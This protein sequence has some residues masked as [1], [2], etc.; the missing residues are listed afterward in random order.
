MVLCV[1]IQDSYISLTQDEFENLDHIPG[2]DTDFLTPY[3]F[4]KSPDEP[5]P[6][7]E[8]LV[9]LQA[10]PSP[11]TV[12]ESSASSTVPQTTSTESSQ[13]MVANSSYLITSKYVHNYCEDGCL[14]S[15]PCP[16]NRL[17]YYYYTVKP[18]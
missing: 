5:Q 4:V 13:Q 11:S 6:N 14:N 12:I 3:A 18:E 9:P 2:V 15:M 16:S 17:S 7:Q 1:C 10:E 8:S